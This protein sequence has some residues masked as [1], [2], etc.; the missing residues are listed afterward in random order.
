[1]LRV[2]TAILLIAAAGLK[3]AGE[4]RGYLRLT[5]AFAS[6][7][8]LH[9]GEMLL[10]ENTHPESAIEVSLERVLGNVRQPGRSTNI[11]KP[12]DEPM[13]LGCNSQG[14]LKQHWEIVEAE[15]VD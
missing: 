5:E 4:P 13:E 9:E 10:I 15:F 7:C 1:M 8:M 12:K 11:L 14:G 2:F 3:A 6:D